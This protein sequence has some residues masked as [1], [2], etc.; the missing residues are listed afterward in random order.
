MVLTHKYDKGLSYHTVFGSEL[1]A[2]FP[3]FD[4]TRRGWKHLTSY[5]VI[6]RILAQTQN[7]KSMKEATKLSLWLTF[8]MYR[9]LSGVEI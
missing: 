9:E 2:L 5:D 3:T 6:E 4:D 1:A 8:Q 7:D